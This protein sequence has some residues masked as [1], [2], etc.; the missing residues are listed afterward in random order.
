VLKLEGYRTHHIQVYVPAGQPLKVHYR[1][2][3]GR[4]E[5]TA[6]LTPDGYLDETRGSRGQQQP[7][8]LSGPGADGD[9]GDVARGE[10][11]ESGRQGGGELRLSVRPGDAVIYVDGEFRGPGRHVRRLELAP[12]RHSIE[13]IRPGF[14]TFERAVD[15]ERDRPV[16]LDVEL[17]PAGS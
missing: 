14:Q 12:G 17:Q 11:D 7:G 5:D 1:M 3:S 8:A 9:R 10:Q 15:V 16:D 2:A 13:V 4:G 6:D